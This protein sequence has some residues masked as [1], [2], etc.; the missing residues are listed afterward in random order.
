MRVSVRGVREPGTKRKGEAVAKR[1]FIEKLGAGVA[2]V[3]LMLAAHGCRGCAPRRGS[4]AD[5]ILYEL[6]IR[7]KTKCDSAED[8]RG[9]MTCPPE[10]MPACSPWDSKTR[11]DFPSFCECDPFRWMPNPD[12][13]P[14]PI[15]VKCVRNPDGGTPICGEWDD[16]RFVILGEDGGIIV[17][18][19]G[20]LL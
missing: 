13:G 3:S 20:G 6:A 1:P 2:L 15:L 5:R 7:D 9:T 16:H 12:G 17:D 4:R 10:Q 18:R 8:C 14:T 19:D 11:R